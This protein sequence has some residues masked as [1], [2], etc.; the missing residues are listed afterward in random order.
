[1][2]R[3]QYREGRPP[4]RPATPGRAVTARRPPIPPVSCPRDTGGRG[5]CGTSRPGSTGTQRRLPGLGGHRHRAQGRTARKAPASRWLRHPCDYQEPL[6]SHLRHAAP[7]P[8]RSSCGPGLRTCQFS[9]RHSAAVS[10]GLVQAGHPAADLGPGVEAE[11]VEDLV[12]WVSMGRSDKNSLSAICLLV[13]RG[14]RAAQRPAACASAGHASGAWLLVPS[15]A[16]VRP[17]RQRRPLLRS[18]LPGRAG[19]PLRMRSCPARGMRRTLTAHAVS[20]LAVIGWRFAY[21]WL[22]IQSAPPPTCP[23]ACSAAL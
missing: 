8:G 20:E 6:T 7:R 22:P 18:S 19:R 1:M 9:S 13:R 3:M 14:Q 10:P 21:Y 11:L 23:F 5:C 2:S 15:L 16:A 17:R 4:S 12:M